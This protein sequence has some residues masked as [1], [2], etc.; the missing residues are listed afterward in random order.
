MIHLIYIYLI[1][2]AILICRDWDNAYTFR[3]NINRA[4]VLLFFPF[5]YLYLI[6]HKLF[7]NDYVYFILILINKNIVKNNESLL[8]HIRMRRNLKNK[9]WNYL[10][11]K[12]VIKIK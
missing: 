2:V 1:I 11:D 3:A 6:F 12:V 7:K 10:A 4:F 9:I 5:L 8:Y